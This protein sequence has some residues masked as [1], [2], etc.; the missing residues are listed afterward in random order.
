MNRRDVLKNIGAVGA[1]ATALTST[2]CSTDDT[3]N[4]GSKIDFKDPSFSPTE[5]AKALLN[6][7]ILSL[8]LAAFIPPVLMQGQQKM[9]GL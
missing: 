7:P 9:R 4:V 2:A 1:G 5:R 6:I 8:V 3:T